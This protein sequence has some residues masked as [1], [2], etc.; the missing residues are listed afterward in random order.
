MRLHHYLPRYDHKSL[1]KTVLTVNMFKVL[2]S[3][4]YLST[5]EVSTEVVTCLLCIL[6]DSLLFSLFQSESRMFNGVEKDCPSP[7]EKLARKE[8][9]KVHI[10][11][12]HEAVIQ[13]VNYYRIWLII[14]DKILL[15]CISIRGLNPHELLC[16]LFKCLSICSM[17]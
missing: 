7:T 12:L 9:L 5:T 13:N 16:M 11:S 10:T 3:F 14:V 8:S 17:C 1:F 15:F 6:T 4:G 2:F